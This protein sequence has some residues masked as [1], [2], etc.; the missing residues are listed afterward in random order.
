MKI[1]MVVSVPLKGS[2]ILNGFAALLDE[3]DNTFPSP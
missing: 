2:F 1:T 3:G